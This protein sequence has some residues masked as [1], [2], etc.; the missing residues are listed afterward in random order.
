MK[1]ALTGVT[2]AHPEITTITLAAIEKLLPANLWQKLPALLAQLPDPDSAV[3]YLE[4]YLSE[5]AADGSPREI[6]NVISFLEH[7]PPALHHLLTIFS[8]SR[9]L[10]DMLVREPELILW[11][12]RSTPARAASLDR[13][14]KLAGM[15]DFYAA[16]KSTDARLV[17]F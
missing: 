3:N 11:I 14:V 12:D 9:F 15:N 13:R 5:E 10:A 17:S 7:N 16:A 6:Q 8:Y 2:F 1:P 4:A